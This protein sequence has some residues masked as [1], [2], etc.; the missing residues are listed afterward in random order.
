MDRLCAASFSHFNDLVDFQVAFARWRR[1]DVVSFIGIPDM[2]GAPVGVRINRYRQDIH[3]TARPH[4]PYRNFTPVGN[5]NFSD[6]IF[7]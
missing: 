2:H 1:P 4:D 6:H 3:F 5:E 7:I